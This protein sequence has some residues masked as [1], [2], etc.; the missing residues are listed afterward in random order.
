[1]KLKPLNKRLFAKRHRRDRKNA[2][3]AARTEKIMNDILWSHF[4]YNGPRTI[5]RTHGGL[6]TGIA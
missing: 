3:R 1:M 6:H 5:F 2:E 4:S